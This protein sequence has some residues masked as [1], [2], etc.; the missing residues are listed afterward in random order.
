MTPTDCSRAWQAEAVE[1]GRLSEMDRASF[2][3][4]LSTCE[5][6]KKAVAE[7]GLLRGIGMHHTPSPTTPL[8]HRRA[9]NELLRRANELTVR[10]PKSV[11]WRRLAATLA[12]VSLVAALAIRLTAS[13]PAAPASVAAPSYHVLPSQGAEWRTLE[14]GPKVRL[15][16]TSGHFEIAVRHLTAGQRFML[17][18]PDGEL[19]VQGTRFVVEVDGRRTL[20]VEVLEGR[21]ALRVRERGRALVTLGPG[22]SFRAASGSMGRPQATAPVQPKLPDP[23]A[24]RERT[25]GTA[26]DTASAVASAS[27]R[28]VVGQPARSA[29]PANETVGSAT[30]SGADF[31]RAMSAFSAGDYG[32]AEKLFQRFV[33]E[34]TTDTRVEDAT[35]LR[36]VARARRGDVEGSRALAAEYLRRYPDGLRRIEAERLA[37]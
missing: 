11:P 22:E 37:E 9:R 32:Q 4:H 30:T 19:E 10:G 25:P 27:G 35:F 34:H 20:G 15:A 29:A 13:R 1:D 5:H 7:L 31:A 3:R 2:E 12:V 26:N 6:C 33:N 14:H 18:L 16:V 23:R 24:S 8:E 21:V 17:E 28:A 36:A